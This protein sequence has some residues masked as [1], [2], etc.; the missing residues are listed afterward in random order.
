[1]LPAA[2]GPATRRADRQPRL[3]VRAGTEKKEEVVTGVSFKPFEEVRIALGGGLWLLTGWAGLPRL[4]LRRQR[5]VGSVRRRH[6]P[7]LPP[8]PAPS[9]CCSM[10]VLQTAKLV[11]LHAIPSQSVLLPYH[12]Q[13]LARRWPLCLL[14]PPRPQAG[15][16]A[17]R[18]PLPAPPP[19]RTR[20][21]QVS[22]PGSVGVA[23]SMPLDSAGQAGTWAVTAYPTHACMPVAGA[24]YARYQYVTCTPPAALSLPAPLPFEKL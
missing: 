1:M 4:R 13:S 24:Q 16:R 18:P 5:G 20:L 7:P 9:C 10:L 8:T 2:R 3:V 21:R 15:Q 14:P 17:G 19:S 23:Y 6:P 11:L 22:Q 12:P